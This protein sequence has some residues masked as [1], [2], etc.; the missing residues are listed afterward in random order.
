M[1]SG[2]SRIFARA[3]AVFTRNPLKVIFGQTLKVDVLE[4]VLKGD[5]RCRFAIY[6]PEEALTGDRKSKSQNRTH[7][8]TNVQISSRLFLGIAGTTAS[9]AG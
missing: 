6:L 8:L 9:S 4:S 1:M 2:W 7:P 3:A 5:E